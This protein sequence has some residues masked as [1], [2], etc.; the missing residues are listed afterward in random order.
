[1]NCF[2]WLFACLLIASSVSGF[3]AGAPD[4]CPEF[5]RTSAA[6]APSAEYAHVYTGVLEI[7]FETGYEGSPFSFQDYRGFTPNEDYRAPGAEGKPLEG[8]AAML[9]EVP[10]FY[11]YT[12]QRV[13]EPGD[14]IRVFDPQTAEVV[15]E[16]VVSRKD[17]ST[18]I[19]IAGLQAQQFSD[20]FV[21]E[22]PAVVF[23]REK[24]MP[25]VFP[26]VEH[27]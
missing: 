16:G 20:Y 10:Y 2:K 14:Y 8:L 1:M 5:L 22:F 12:W 15:L 9:S 7:F 21:R 26:N 23:T 18:P 24:V 11:G 3:S 17:Y 19:Q 27:P 13:L 25:H 6:K 4:L